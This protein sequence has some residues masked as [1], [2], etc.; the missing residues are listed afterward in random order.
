MCVYMCMCIRASVCNKKDA[1]LKISR[2]I[3]A[4]VRKCVPHKL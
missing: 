1:I 2:E 4:V 3:C